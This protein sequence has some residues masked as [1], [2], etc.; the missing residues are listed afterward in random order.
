MIESAIIYLPDTESRRW[1]LRRIAGRTIFL[2]VLKAAERAGI[3]VIGLPGVLRG[4]ADERELGSV[5]AEL[6][7]LDRFSLEEKAA[8]TAAPALLLPANVLLS[9]ARVRSLIEAG[10]SGDGAAL[11][12]LKG[13]PTPVLAAPPGLVAGLWEL[14]EKGLPLGEE[15]EARLRASRPLLLSGEGFAVPVTDARSLKAA[16]DALY[17]SLGIEADSLVDR[18]INRRGSRF[19]TRCL[20]RLP[21][22]PNQV[23]LLSLAIGGAGVWALWNATVTSALVGLA[24]Y[25]LSVVADHSDGEIARLTFQESSFGER[26]DFTADCLIHAGTAL[27]MGVT[28]RSVGGPLMAF[29]GGAAAFGIIVSALFTRFRSRSGR[30][31][32]PLGS[33]LSNVG[34]RDPFYLVMAAF[35]LSLWQAPGLLPYLVGTLAVG[36]QIYWLMC[37]A[38]LLRRSQ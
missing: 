2:R 16:V 34:N 38:H 4:E 33:A 25:M 9:Q 3:R 14:I 11:D 17:Q 27:A 10:G 32:E 30:P 22:T 20:I 24:L 36:T 26:L 6:L 29:A 35:I 5:N 28:A 15:L 37:L 13:S 18:Y 7:W 19:L 8:F 21:V 23:T 31:N 12:E 1:A